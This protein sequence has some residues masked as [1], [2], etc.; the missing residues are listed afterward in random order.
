M[1]RRW[2]IRGLALMLLAVCVVVWMGSY[3]WAAL[4]IYEPVADR[5]L[6]LA[7]E[8]GS[9]CSWEWVRLSN[10]GYGPMM[11]TGWRWQFGRTNPA[12][13]KDFYSD[14]DYHFA[15]FACD[16]VKGRNWT[17]I[18][19]L[20]FP[21]LLSTLLLWLAWRKI[22]PKPQGFPVEVVAAKTEG[23]QT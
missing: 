12:N 7:V 21:T 15:G 20:W 10:S 8:C 13:F 14:T 19:P 9:V 2:I 22:R 17:V 5:E 11:K 3:R 18:I 6:I 4:A 1:N 23:R 16:P